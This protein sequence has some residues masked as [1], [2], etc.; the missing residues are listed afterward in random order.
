MSKRRT[1]KK[2]SS[3]LLASII[4]VIILFGA[5]IGSQ[6]YPTQTPAIQPAQPSNPIDQMVQA[7]TGNPII[8]SFGEALG[9]IEPEEV[10]IYAELGYQSTTGESIVFQSMSGIQVGFIGLSGIYVK[11]SLGSYKALKL[12]DENTDKEGMIWVRPIIKIKLY[13]GTPE[14]YSF[15]TKVKIKSGGELLAEKILTKSGK[16]MPPTKIT[17]DKVSVKGRALHLLMLGKKTDAIALIKG[18]KKPS[19]IPKIKAAKIQPGAKQICFYADYQGIV[20]FKEEEEPVVKELKD[21]KLGCFDFDLKETGDFEMIVEK[22]VTIAPIAEVM[23]TVESGMAGIRQEVVTVTHTVTIPYTSY[24][25]VVSG[26][27]YTKTEYMTRTLTQVKTRW[28]T[29]TT[30]VTVKVPEPYP[31]TKTVTI[32]VVK[33]GNVYGPLAGVVITIRWPYSEFIFIKGG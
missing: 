7:I 10:G 19:E 25:T 21:V 12:Y 32:T 16:G 14:T 20:K 29:T 3:L 5:A 31:V 18:L 17:M 30:T 8:R 6:S 1:T 2:K 26:T 24:T 15:Q 23:T 27:T 11:P 22:N 13:N 9:L 28:K 4:L 33:H